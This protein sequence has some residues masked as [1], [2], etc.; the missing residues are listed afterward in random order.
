SLAQL[1]A[2]AGLSLREAQKIAC[3]HEIWPE[4]Y[5]RNTS[6]FSA[7]E[8]A[9]LLC[10]EVLQVGLGGLGGHLLDMLLRLGVG[11]IT[12]AD[13]DIFEESN[14]NRQL[15]ATSATLGKAKARAA[16]EYAARINPAV[17]FMPIQIFLRGERLLEALHGKNLVLD[18]LGGLED[19]KALHD[20]AAQMHVPMI[21][22]GVAGFV[23]WVAVVR[24]GDPGPA[25][26]LGHGKGVEESLGNLAPTVAFA[27]SLQCAETAKILTGRTCASGLTIF[28][29]ADQSITKLDL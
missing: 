6:L 11:H 13:G 4:R 8:Q 21:S 2:D 16:A 22:A 18:A 26:F 14:F 29:L 12:G 25:D 15:L 28:D 10:A 19:R 20:A 3:D 5:V 27:A 23:G 17:E 24:P 7:A 1:A 9:D